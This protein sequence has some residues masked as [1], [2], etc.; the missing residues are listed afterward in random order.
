[1]KELIFATGNAHKVFEVGQ[2]LKSQIDLDIKSLADIGFFEEI[3]EDGNT[4]EANALIKARHIH[5]R[6]NKN[7]FS[8]D[9]GLEVEA[10]NGDP[11][12][13]TARYAGP[14]KSFSD[15]M[16][17]LIKNLQNTSNRKARF[18]AIIAL[19]VN[20]QEFLFEGICEGSIALTRS[21]VEGFGYDP[22]FIPK[23]HTIS[24]A[25]MKSEEKIHMSHRTK[26]FL[27]MHKFLSEI[28]I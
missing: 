1:M 13:Y 6:F 19:I 16:D 20:D 4:L 21:G 17:L 5:Q 25:E 7:V 24:F 9:T 15:N 3:V 10:L 8:E 27:K 28:Q 26:A 23:G 14:H 22:I 12:V 11:G 2:L 18:R